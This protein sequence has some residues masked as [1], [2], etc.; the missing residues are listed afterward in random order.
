MTAA[1]LEMIF[2]KMQESDR[3]MVIICNRSFA[4]Q[5]SIRS[6]RFADSNA[7]AVARFEE[8]GYDFLDFDTKTGKD[9]PVKVGVVT[10]TPDNYQT[11]LRIL[12][13]TNGDTEID[14]AVSECFENL[15]LTVLEEAF[16]ATLEEVKEASLGVRESSEELVIS[17]NADG[18]LVWK[19][20]YR[21]LLEEFAS[22]KN[23]NGKPDPD[24]QR[25]AFEELV[26]LKV[27]PDEI[28]SFPW[29]PS[30]LERA[31]LDGNRKFIFQYF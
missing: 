26:K 4:P 21:G 30:V 29:T 28:L 7:D 24:L 15:P 31:I 23:S 12:K 1:Q 2:K 19:S 8:R 20:R 6:S 10:L 25:Y 17:E 9:V 16:N 22:A 13:K 3:D 18:K 27:D 14:A 5:F 11:A